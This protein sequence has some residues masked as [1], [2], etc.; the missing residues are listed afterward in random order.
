MTKEMKAKYF[1]IRMR[2]EPLFNVSVTLVFLFATFI[3][4]SDL[5]IIS[6][7]S[8]TYYHWLVIVL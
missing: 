5:F 7:C 2:F 1:E 6:I 8:D 4:S 3:A